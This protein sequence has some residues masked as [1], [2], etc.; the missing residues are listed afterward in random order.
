MVDITKIPEEEL[1]NDYRI[2]HNERQF[3]EM[4]MFAGLKEYNGVDLAEQ[5]M[6][7][8]TIMEKIMSE[9]NR[10]GLT[11]LVPDGFPPSHRDEPFC[12]CD[13]CMGFNSRK[14]TAGKA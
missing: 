8:N 14:P 12:E 11:P 10:R 13:F 3:C 1:N 4:A 9:I 6:K 5:I 2:A 7:A